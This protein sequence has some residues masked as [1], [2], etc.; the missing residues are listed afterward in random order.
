MTRHSHS[1]QGIAH[2]AHIEAG[3]SASWFEHSVRFCQDGRKGNAV[4][5]TERDRI[6][7]VG[8]VFEL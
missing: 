2:C 7:V 8:V 3:K 1:Q 6:Q 5:H 4:P